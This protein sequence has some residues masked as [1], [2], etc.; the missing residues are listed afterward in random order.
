MGVPEI[1]SV[2]LGAAWL[3]FLIFYF[4]HHIEKRSRTLKFKNR[5][6]FESSIHD[7]CVLYI[8]Y[9]SNPVRGFD[10]HAATLRIHDYYKWDKRSEKY[11]RKN[12]F[13][14]TDTFSRLAGK[15]DGDFP[16]LFCLSVM[17][18]YSGYCDVFG[19][20]L[21][22]Y[23]EKCGVRSA[24]GDYCAKFYKKWKAFFNANGNKYEEVLYCIAADLWNCGFVFADPAAE[25]EQTARKIIKKYQ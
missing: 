3:A 2:S 7:L 24:L 13:P 5:C 22:F 11:K 6:S 16:L 12:P 15:C 18:K 9:S 19:E 23:V 21:S 8:G 4:F 10:E 25:I 17:E 14:Q 20:F 1:I